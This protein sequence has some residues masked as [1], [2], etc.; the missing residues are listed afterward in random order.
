MIL[1]VYK[2]RGWTS[3]DVVAKVRGILSTKLGKKVKVGHA[4][5]LDPLAE[6]VLIILTGED[7]KRQPEFMSLKKEYICEIIFGVISPTY[8][9]EG[10]LVYQNAVLDNLQERLTKILPKYKGEISQRVPPY[11]AVKLRGKA[12]YKIARVGKI[13]LNE[14]PVKKV[15]IYELELLD[16]YNK[17]SLPTAKLRILCSKGTYIRSLAHD[18][19][20]DLGT[21]GVLASLVRTKIGEYTMEKA[22]KIF[23]M[24]NNPEVMI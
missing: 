18:L 3:F 7:T 8:D 5:T 13:K 23:E 14:L 2:E 10:E 24:E 22:L 11:S 16:F 4:G 20:K 21:G 9:L 17:N 1:N 12:L 15:I 19:G 6:G